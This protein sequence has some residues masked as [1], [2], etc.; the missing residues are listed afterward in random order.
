MTFKSVDSYRETKK[1]RQSG[2][3]DPVYGD[4]KSQLRDL[5]IN[6]VQKND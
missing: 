5:R 6:W 1:F 4:L 2:I 3:A